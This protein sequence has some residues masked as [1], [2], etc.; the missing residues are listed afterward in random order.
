MLFRENRERV[1][2]VGLG[3]MGKTQIA[4]ELAYRVQNREVEGVAE[5]YSVF[6]VQ[7][8]SMAAFHKT[9][10]E[11]VRL[12]NIAHGDDNPKEALQAY[13][14]SE[15]AGYWLLVLDNVDDAALLDGEPGQSAGLSDFFPRNPNGR[16]L[17]TTRQTSVAVDVAGT[18]VVEL[19]SMPFAEA[20][21]LM[22]RLLLDKDQVQNTQSTKELLEKLACLPLTVAQAAAYMNRNKA[23]I[24]R[25]LE[26]CRSA[27][28]NMIDLLSRRLRDDAHYSDAQGAVATTWTVSF[29]AIRGTD[30]NAVRILSFIRWIESKAIPVSMLPGAE[31]GTDLDDSIGLLC[32]YGF[33]RWREDSETLDMHS[34]VHL[35]LRLWLDQ[36]MDQGL[37][38]ESMAIEHLNDAFP[39]SNKWENRQV[40][41]K[42]LPHVL[43]LINEAGLRRSMILQS[44]SHRVGNCLQFDGRIKEM[45]DVY[46]LL[47]AVQTETLAETHPVRL[48]SQLGLATAYQDDGQA[49]EATKILERIATIPKE[50]L[51]ETDTARLASQHLLACSY[52]LNDEVGEGIKLLE[53]VVSLGKETL[54]EEHPYRLSYG[55]T[56]EHALAIAYRK[57]GQVEEAVMILEHLVAINE[58]TLPESHPWRLASLYE[59]SNAYGDID[60]PKEQ[61][62]MLEYVV[63][64]WEE[65]LDQPRSDQ[66]VAQNGLVRAYLANHQFKEAVEMLEDVVA[67]RKEILAVDHPDRLTSQS[68]LAYAYQRANQRIDYAYAGD[69]G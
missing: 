66:L 15:A 18:N 2:V 36:E 48:Q 9:A 1:A 16:L 45:V 32:G 22:E 65:T 67:K 7:A 12:L 33:L 61:I 63:G 42:Y 37:T 62:R 24:V 21:L 39:W 69:A 54:E 27:D 19:L 46:E 38:T 40:W 52:L 49:N 8:Q 11:L 28:Q 3:G 64:V 55:Q 44:L 34:L 26:R 29:E 20:Y 30:A 5:R 23:P 43:P 25:Y 17:L 10:G 58:T 57:N 47:V 56:A 14:S 51:P 50:M 41:Q 53:H 31:S 4:L 59:L 13:L 60:Q 68:M 6:W 35:V